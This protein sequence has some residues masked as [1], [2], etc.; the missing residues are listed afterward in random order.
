MRSSGRPRTPV[1]LPTTASTKSAADALHAIGAG[2]VERLAGG[3]VPLD[4]GV[5]HRHERHVARRRA[6]SGATRP[7]RPTPRCG[8]G[9]SVRRAAAAS[10]PR[11]LRRRLAD[12]LAVD[13][14]RGVAPATTTVPGATGRGRHAPCPPRA[15]R[16]SPTATPRPAGSRR[17]RVGARRRPRPSRPSNSHRRGEPLARTRRRPPRRAVIGWGRVTDPVCAELRQVGADDGGRGTYSCPHGADSNAT[18]HRPRRR[19]VRL[20]RRVDG[21]AQGRV[22]QRPRARRWW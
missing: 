3:D 1:T 8:P 14:D 20:Q 16:P 17:R 13:L 19:G 5:G 11:P 7:R 2:L 6:V 15:A 12:D 9:A 4:L 22:R 10:A 18:G 21:V